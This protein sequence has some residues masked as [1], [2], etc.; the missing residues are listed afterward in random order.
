MGLGIA[1][2]V[3]ISEIRKENN[4]EA[5]RMPAETAAKALG[6]LIGV[7]IER[8]GGIINGSESI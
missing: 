3:S 2:L 4:V 7:N 8:Q 1:T 5:K 6:E